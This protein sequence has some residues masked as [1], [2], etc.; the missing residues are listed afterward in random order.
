MIE[1]AETRGEGPRIL[2]HAVA[3][4]GAGNA[5][6]WAV[7]MASAFGPGKRGVRLLVRGVGD[8][9]TGSTVLTT[10][11]ARAMIAALQGALDDFEAAEAA[12]GD[13]GLNFKI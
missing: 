13:A 8:E 2:H 4:D 11:E 10:S 6:V 3:R 7:A 5:L 12:A 9:Q 1:A